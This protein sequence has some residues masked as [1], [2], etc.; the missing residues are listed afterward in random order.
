MGACLL[1]AENPITV[2]SRHTEKANPGLRASS[3]YFSPVRL[4]SLCKVSLLSNQSHVAAGDLPLEV[5]MVTVVQCNSLCAVL[6]GFFRLLIVLLQSTGKVWARG[7]ELSLPAA[8]TGTTAHVIVCWLCCRGTWA[9]GWM[10]MGRRR[11]EG[12]ELK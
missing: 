6:W 2:I 7:E 4:N 8:N 12:K 5:C 11:R 10:H 3:A 9:D 1:Q